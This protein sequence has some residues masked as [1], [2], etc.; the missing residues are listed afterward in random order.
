MDATAY[1]QVRYPTS[2]HPDTLPSR[3]AAL[4][5]LYGRP[6]APMGRARMLEVGCGD[7]GNLLSLAAIAPGAQL[8]GFDLAEEPVADGRALAEAAGLGNVRLYAGDILDPSVTEGP[9]DYI[10]AHG[11][12]AWVPEPVRE[13]L[14]ALIART[15][16]PEGIAFV[17]YNVMPG[18]GLRV[19]ISQILRAHVAAIEAP[20]ARL[21]EARAFLAWLETQWAEGTP[22]Q[23]ALAAQART[24]LERP[25]AVL[26]HDELGEGFAPLTLAEFVAAAARHELTYLG[27]A[28]AVPNLPAFFPEEAPD[29]LVSRAGGSWL[30]YEQLSD[31]V[32]QLQFRESLLCRGG[33]VMRRLDTERLRDLFVHG[34]L[35][36][37]EG[38]GGHVF[39]T[40]TR[41]VRVE[42]D[43][44]VLAE[45]LDRIAEA[46]PAAIPLADLAADTA[47]GRAIARLALSGVVS[48]CTEP[49]P[50]TPVVPERPATSALARRQ[51]AQGMPTIA[52]LA[53]TS[54]GLAEAQTVQ[55]LT[56]L[57]GTR[58]VVA[59][60]REL[61]QFTG[62]TETEVAEWLPDALAALARNGFVA[63]RTA[64]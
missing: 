17:S 36:R 60:T 35:R 1:D 32:S 52:T 55:L 39:F 4:A 30:A 48:L 3:F 26:Y 50:V 28:Q 27:D 16:S 18:C 41:G 49:P 45:V 6:F 44:G 51:A 23:R 25:P 13:A 22:H 63:A 43:G 61:A 12:Y 10:I 37:S 7:G 54:I 19:A 33:P 42:T 46:H 14:M 64:S 47:L 11:V 40:D 38:P 56:L 2:A 20:G 8:E 58:D 9:F 24:M 5:H 15:L 31:T 34:S 29:E 62:E 59:L 57:D 21:E 53:H